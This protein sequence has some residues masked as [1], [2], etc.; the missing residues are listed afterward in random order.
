MM[1]YD[2]SRTNL[3]RKQ[4][5]LLQK[6]G[7]DMALLDEVVYMLAKGETLPERY[8]DHPLKGNR[9]GLRDC[10][11]LNDWVLLYKIEKSVLLLVLVETGT[12][13]DIF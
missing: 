10:H 4:Y 11:I 1:K 12:H 9:K 8:L 3:F 6:R 5:K 7:Y 13:S 2:I